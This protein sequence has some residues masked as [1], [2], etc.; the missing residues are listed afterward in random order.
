MRLFAEQESRNYWVQH[1]KIPLGPSPASE[2]VVWKI[3]P[4]ISGKSKFTNTLTCES[5]GKE[6]KEGSIV[7]ESKVCDTSFNVIT[8]QSFIGKL[9]GNIDARVLILGGVFLFS[10]IIL[11]VLALFAF[12]G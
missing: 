8:D 5:I 6:R 11:G 7:V 12:F 9:F 3:M 4:K 10:L 1:N 2:N